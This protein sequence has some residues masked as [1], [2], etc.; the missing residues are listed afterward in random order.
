[1]R[2]ILFAVVIYAAYLAFNQVTQDSSSAYTKELSTEINDSIN[3]ARVNLE[4][5]RSAIRRD[6][7][8]S[9]FRGDSVYP[10]TLSTNSSHLFDNVLMTPILSSGS[11]GWKSL[12]QESYQ[13]TYGEEPDSNVVFRYNNNT[14]EILCVSEFSKCILFE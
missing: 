8:R 12:G 11:I 9:V 10:E 14:G 7:K 1:M 2:F 3:K 5:I 13:Y 4:S 6:Y